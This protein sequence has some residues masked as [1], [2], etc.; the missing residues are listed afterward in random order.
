MI[1]TAILFALIALCFVG[2]Y[3]LD[4]RAERRYRARV[5]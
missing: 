5:H 4:R 1:L 2:A 3:R